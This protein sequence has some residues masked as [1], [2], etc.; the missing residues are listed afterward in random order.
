MVAQHLALRSRGAN[1]GG[2][3]LVDAMH[4]DALPADRG[5]KLDA[6]VSCL[7]ALEQGKTAAGCGYPASS[8][9]GEIGPALAAAQA[10]QAGKLT[11]WRARASELD[12]LEVSADQL[13]KA[14]KPFG[15]IKVAEVRQAEPAAIVSAVMALLGQ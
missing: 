14:R 6:V 2:L 15:E 1:V 12:S 13:R 7:N 5:A 8:I 10:A 9:N 3:V 11:Y 4:E